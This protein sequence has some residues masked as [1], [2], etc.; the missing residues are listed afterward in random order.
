V[1]E[2]SLWWDV[3]F[4][5]FLQLLRRNETDW[6][7]GAGV[8]GLPPIWIFDADDLKWKKGSKILVQKRK[9]MSKHL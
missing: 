8:L 5:T 7:V 6:T 4:A 2:I 3:G 9:K 1:H